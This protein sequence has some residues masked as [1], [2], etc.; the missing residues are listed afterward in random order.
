MKALRCPEPRVQLLPVFRDIKLHSSQ[1][2]PG[3]S[4]LR[5]LEFISLAWDTPHQ[6]VAADQCLGEPGSK[7]STCLHW[8]QRYLCGENNHPYQRNSLLALTLELP[9]SQNTSRHE[10][11][12]GT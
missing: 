1:L 12:L 10:I 8:L 2:Y 7:L 6:A 5:Y 4:L 11:P 9:T 3:H